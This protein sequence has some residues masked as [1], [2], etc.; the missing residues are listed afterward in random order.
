MNTQQSI[1]VMESTNNELFF[2][3]REVAKRLRCSQALIYGLISKGKL[4]G[5]RIGSGRGGIR[6]SEAYIQAFLN[7]ARLKSD[8]EVPASKPPRQLLKHLKLT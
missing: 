2:T 3:V 6:I 1:A 5:F 4:G 7:S 8:V